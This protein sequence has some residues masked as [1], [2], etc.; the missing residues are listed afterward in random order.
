[1]NLILKKRYFSFFLNFQRIRKK[2]KDYINNTKQFSIIFAPHRLSKYSARLSRRESPRG[3]S[4]KATI[5]FPNYTHIIGNL[6]Q[7]IVAVGSFDELSSIPLHEH[8]LPA[9]R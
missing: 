7:A 6:G 5:S 1:M 8:E 3:I 9:E 4:A 2:I